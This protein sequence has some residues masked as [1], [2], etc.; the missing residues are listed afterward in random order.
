MQ[1][2]SKID[3][4]WRREKNHYLNKIK[5]VQLRKSNYKYFKKLVESINMMGKTMENFIRDRNSE[6]ESNGNFRTK[7]NLK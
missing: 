2:P 1:G 3:L 4:L 7:K 5:H 6:E